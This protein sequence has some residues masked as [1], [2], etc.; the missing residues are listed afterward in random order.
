[1][2]ELA[3]APA[4][5]SGADMATH[6]AAVETVALAARRSAGCKSPTDPVAVA[7]PEFQL[8]DTYPAQFA[9]EL[10]A[11]PLLQHEYRRQKDSTGIQA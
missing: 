9:P 4:S 3:L 10:P 6:L 7:V 8:L 2:P 11:G 5:A 1:M